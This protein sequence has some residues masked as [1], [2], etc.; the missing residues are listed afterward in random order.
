VG[1]PGLR[2]AGHYTM[3]VTKVSF[4]H[5]EA[6]LPSERISYANPR[7]STVRYAI[8]AAALRPRTLVH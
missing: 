6:I 3:L 2:E 8:A 5:S 4:S 7:T 1:G